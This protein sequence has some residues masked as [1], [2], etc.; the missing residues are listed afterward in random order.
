MAS[1][2]VERLDHLGVL[3]EVIKD[4]GLIAL[5]DARL[6][7][8]DQEEL[9]PGEAVAGMLRNSLG[10]SHRPLSLTPQLFANK[11]LALRVREGVGAARF[12]RCKLGRT[13]DEASAYGCAG[14]LSALALAGCH[15]AGMD[16][17]F[18]PLDPTSLALTGDDGPDS[19]E[20]AL[21]ITPGD[22]KDPRPDVQQAVLARRVS[23]DGGVPFVSQSWEGQASDTQRFQDRA[24][25]L[26]ATLQS[27]PTPRYLGADSKRYHTDHAG[28]RQ[29]LG[30]I[31]RVPTTLTLVSQVI[32]HALQWGEAWQCLDATTRY[33]R[34]ELCHDGMA[35]RWLV[36]YA[37]A[38]FARA[39][40]TVTQ[41]HKRAYEAIDKHLFHVQAQRLEPPE[42]AHEAL[43]TLAQAWQS[44][45]LDASHLIEHNRDACQGR[46]TSTTPVKAIAWHSQRQV[47]PADAALEQRK[48]CQACCVLG[49]TIAAEPLSDP[50]V[51]AASKGPARA[52]GGCRF[53]TDPLFFVSSLFV[54][55]P[56][57]MQG[58]VMVRTLALGVYAVAQR[59]VRKQ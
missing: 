34:L 58:L 50:A 16:G 45:Q 1:V 33:Q 56:S 42:A 27:S 4:L 2:S 46:P 52:E 28:N 32:G 55:K 3:S 11:P 13:L 29:A 40:A 36:G 10:F 47:R 17:R 41:A 39:E 23:Q 51:I 18:N 20:Q 8:D 21:P 19:A 22:A 24:Q 7:P 5:I 53:R 15:H 14:L 57:R 35:Q 30:C 25:A 6:V 49:T 26:R 12:N 59:R 38:A 9:T 31:T 37:E 43:E 54:K 48:P 44:P